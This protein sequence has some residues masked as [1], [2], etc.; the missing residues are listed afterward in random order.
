[1]SAADDQRDERGAE[2]SG[3]TSLP[4]IPPLYRDI[5][6]AELAQL[7]RRR[8]RL[9]PS[10]E[11]LWVG[12]PQAVP[13]RGMWLILPPLAFAIAAVGACFA[14][15]LGVADLP[16]IRSALSWA[17]FFAAFGAAV[18]IG[19]SWLREREEYVITTQRV[20]WRR[21]A[22]TR[23]IDR[24]RVGLVRVI[25]HPDVPIVGD[26]ELIVAVP[27]GPL[28]RRFRVVLRDVRRPD[29]L[30][31]RVRGTDPGDRA[32]DRDVPLMDRL[33][34][35]ERVYWGG[36]PEG[37]HL[38]VRE[39]ANA[40]YGLTVTL[41]GLLYLYRA[42]EIVVG[43]E[44]SEGLVVF[45]FA[46]WLLLI[47]VLL[48]AA[49]I[50]SVGAG[51]I[52]FG[53]VRARALGEDTEY[54]LTDRRVLIR[55]GRTELSVDRARIVDVAR[56]PS[57]RGMAHLFLVLDAKGGRALAD[58]GALRP[59]LPARDSVEPV[60]YEVAEPDVVAA[61]LLGEPLPEELPESDGD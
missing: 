31:A 6:A 42:G 5:D 18:A 57:R 30:A 35:T 55:R 33:D 3:R 11:V 1:M 9:I 32:G 20:L 48:S 58:S 52:W 8:W 29:V 10:E 37:T 45:S 26:L 28:A 56:K 19:P 38:G 51:L 54:V 17:V 44:Q 50:L 7:D 36:H 60:L 34:G 25:W 22:W 59:L 46:W 23:D 41:T 2:G 14:L 24:R 13:R 27:F 43:L 39:L 16:G 47:A 12:R 61:V 53:L 49:S 40:F 4:S 21:G 15:L